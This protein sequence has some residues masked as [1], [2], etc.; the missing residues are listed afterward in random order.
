CRQL[1]FE[2]PIPEDL[3]SEIFRLRRRMEAEIAKEGETSFNIKTGRGGLVDVE[4]I[5]QYL[6]LLHGKG[7]SSLQQPNTLQ[8]LDGLETEGLMPPEDA[9]ILCD[10]YKFLRRLENKLR[11]LHDHSISELSANRGYL[12]KL[13]R[14]LGYPERPRRPEES[15]LED[16]R[17]ITDK[18]REI[19]E[20]YLR[21]DAG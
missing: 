10:G 14:T 3:Q 17:R 20:R 11:L 6:Q 4:F 12:R 1:V 9:T 18:V 2:R 15:F 7:R 8:V 16:Y 13:A 5:S 21:P 19:F